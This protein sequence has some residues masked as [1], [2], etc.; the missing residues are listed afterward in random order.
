LEDHSSTRR[1][2]EAVERY[3]PP[4]GWIST[5]ISVVI[6]LMRGEG[7]HIREKW[8]DDGTHYVDQIRRRSK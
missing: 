4:N 6:D 8:I 2:P 3:I 7:T 5:Y 1:I